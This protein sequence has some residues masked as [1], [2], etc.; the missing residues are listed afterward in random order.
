MALMVL[1]FSCLIAT[2]VSIV[3]LT[4]FGAGWGV[5]LLLYA[6]LSLVPL[7]FMVLGAALRSIHMGA[8]L[9]GHADG[10]AESRGGPQTAKTEVQALRLSSAM[11]TGWDARG[12][13]GGR[14][15]SSMTSDCI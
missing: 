7:F 14:V 8:G 12:S 2:V 10:H 11:A 6:T 4:G 5:V 15:A 13:T 3:A 9:E 1:V